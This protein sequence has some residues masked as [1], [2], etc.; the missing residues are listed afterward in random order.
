MDGVDCGLELVRAGLVTPQAVL[1]DG[2]AL[3]DEIVVPLRPVLVGE[4]PKGTV[5]GGTRRPPGVDKQ[6]QREQARTSGSSGISSA[7]SRPRRIAS[8]E[9]SSRTSCSP[10]LAAYPSL[11]MR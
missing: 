10:E 2:L 8:A 5:G 6:Q 11:K 3:L 1:D 9:R 7:S 4:Q